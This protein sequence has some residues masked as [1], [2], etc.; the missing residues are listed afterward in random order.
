MPVPDADL[1]HEDAG[2]RERVRAALAEE[3]R[4]FLAR[5]DVV[6]AVV[7]LDK[8]PN[9]LCRLIRQRSYIHIGSVALLKFIDVRDHALARATPGGKAFEELDALVLLW[10][11]ILD[12]I[13]R[14]KPRHRERLAEPAPEQLLGDLDEQDRREQDDREIGG[15]SHVGVEDYRSPTPMS[16]EH[17]LWTTRYYSHSLAERI[18]T[19]ET[20]LLC[21]KVHELAGPEDD[22]PNWRPLTSTLNTM[23]C[24]CALACVSGAQR[25]FFIVAPFAVM[26]NV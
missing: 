25:A 14:R 7:V 5:G 22:A 8:L 10:V 21:R 13:S 20:A 17:F 16:D 24:F 3:V 19:A 23:L 6:L 2:V 11:R 9:L 1:L 12:E 18:Q 15:R 4:A 26:L